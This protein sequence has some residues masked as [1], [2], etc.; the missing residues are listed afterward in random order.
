MID[1]RGDYRGDNYKAIGDSVAPWSRPKLKY[2]DSEFHLLN[3][4]DQL[5]TVGRY[6]VLQAPRMGE[7]TRPSRINRVVL[8]E[9]AH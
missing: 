9:G 3:E 1:D 7:T 6:L 2:I 4:V 5:T 8:T